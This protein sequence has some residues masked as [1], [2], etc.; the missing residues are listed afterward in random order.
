MQT[1]DEIAIE[2]AWLYYVYEMNQESIARQLGLSR[3]KV[4]RLLAAAR[5]NGTVQITV[6]HE[7]PKAIEL[8]RK[9]K[10][11]LG[12]GE[13]I[14]S[15]PLFLPEIYDE[16]DRAALQRRATGVAAANYISCRC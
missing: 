2:V 5:A 9:L 16:K 7:V 15:P 6:T 10:D 1:E 4:M 8:S 11:F 13:C 14:V 3:F 12:V